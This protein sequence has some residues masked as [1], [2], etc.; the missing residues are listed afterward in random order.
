[1]LKMSTISFAAR[2]ESFEKVQNRFVNCFIRQIVPHHIACIAALGSAV[3]CS[4]GFSLSFT[5]TY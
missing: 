4:F 3:L 1:M 5:K 2:R